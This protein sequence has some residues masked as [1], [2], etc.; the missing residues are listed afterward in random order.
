MALGWTQLLTGMRS[1]IFRGGKGGQCVRLTTLPPSWSLK[2]LDISGPYRDCITFFFTQW[3]HLKTFNGIQWYT[4]SPFLKWCALFST[5]L[6]E[7]N[8]R[9]VTIQSAICIQ[10]YSCSFTK[11]IPFTWFLLYYGRVSWLDFHTGFKHLVFIIIGIGIKL[12]A[13]INEQHIHKCFLFCKL[14]RLMVTTWYTIM[15]VYC[16]CVVIYEG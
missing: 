1:K 15:S 3:L 12:Y 4:W 5:W 7:H 13:V 14:L 11:K 10:D 9:S 8:L 6:L 16:R 2:L